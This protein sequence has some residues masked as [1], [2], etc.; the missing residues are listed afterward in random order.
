MAGLYI[1]RSALQNYVTDTVASKY[2]LAVS[3]YDSKLDYNKPVGIWQYAGNAG[4]CDGV[5]GAVDL[6][7]CYKDY[8]SVIK[9][10]GL[11]GFKAVQ[12]KLKTLDQIAKEVIQGLWG[13]GEDRKKRL[14]AAGYNYN[15][16]QK[17]VNELLSGESKPKLK[18]IDEIAKEVIRGD[19]G[20][21][22]AR[23][24]KL[25]AAGYDYDKVQNRVNA[26]LKKYELLCR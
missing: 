9:A 3:E 16:V 11:N 22:A 19:W 2:E 17:R 18:S 5:N 24:K 6:D 15:T 14:T 25:I 13:A 20:A 26:L 4:R 7:V 10:Q 23:K 8:P 1:Y 21:G 12:V